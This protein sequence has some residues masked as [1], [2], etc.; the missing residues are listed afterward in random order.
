[1]LMP[2]TT[3][4]SFSKKRTY[5]RGYYGHR[6]AI[7]INQDY[8]DAHNNLGVSLKDHG[9]LDEA[10]EAYKAIEIKDYRKAYFNMGFAFSELGRLD[11]AIEA[12]KK[13]MSLNQI[14][15]PGIILH[16]AYRL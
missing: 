2:T 6:K 16:F 15:K 3:L 5:R 11:E 13:A 10:I 12:Y 4:V 1:M 7:E 8:P 9:K 14:M